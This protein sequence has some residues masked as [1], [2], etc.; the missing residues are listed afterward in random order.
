MKAYRIRKFTKEAYWYLSKEINW[1]PLLYVFAAIFIILMCGTFA[2]E[3]SLWHI[4]VMM[5][6]EAIF[7]MLCVAVGY[8]TDCRYKMRMKKRANKMKARRN[9]VLYNLQRAS[10]EIK[11][12]RLARE[13]I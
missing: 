7:A 8:D 11:L 1:A 5:L 13:N 4:V 9:R 10:R 6:I 3:A 12:M 2:I